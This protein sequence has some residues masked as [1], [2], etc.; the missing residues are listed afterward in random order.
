MLSHWK[1]SIL[2]AQ[3]FKFRIIHKQKLIS[4]SEILNLCL[5]L[6]F[7]LSERR[8]LRE[9]TLV[10]RFFEGCEALGEIIHF[11]L[12]SD[13]REKSYLFDLILIKNFLKYCIKN[14]RADS[15]WKISLLKRLL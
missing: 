1:F 3:E 14:I 15:S 2:S 11:G 12:L 4:S 13:P 5:F 10:N 8:C 7:V 6:R 9:L